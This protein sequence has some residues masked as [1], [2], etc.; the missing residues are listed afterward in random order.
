MSG[1][2]KAVRA[3]QAALTTF[4]EVEPGE[5]V[6]IVA[7]ESGMEENGAIVDALFGIA[8]QMGAHPTTVVMEDVPPGGSVGSLPAAVEAG[9]RDTDVLIGITLTTL[10]SVTHHEVPDGLREAG[11][12]RGLVMA[13]RSYETLTSDFSLSADYERILDVQAAFADRFGDGEEVH[14]TSSLGMDVTMGIAE[15]A[16]VHPGGFATEPGEFT[17]VT[18]AEYGQAPDAGTAEGTFVVDGPVQEHGWPD[19]PLSVEVRSGRITDV[20]G[21][22]TI[23]SRLRGL[24]SEYENADNVAEVALGANPVRTDSRDMNV[25]K[26]T[27]GTAHTA[28]GSGAAYGQGVDSP[29][30]LDLIMLAPSVA[31]DGEQVLAEGELVLDV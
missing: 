12:L 23:A 22:G 24:L 31:V 18:W 21:G 26:N 27:L 1:S 11:E 5:D 6:L 19:S 28:M 25:V 2:Q 8:E 20:A 14:L 13:N 16:E 9:M 7:D 3:A 15:H 10:A 4:T 29:V 30:H 17:T